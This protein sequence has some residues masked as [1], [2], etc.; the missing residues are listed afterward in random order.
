M[1]KLLFICGFPSG[2]TDLIKSI[3]NVHPDIYINGEMPLLYKIHKHGYN[4]STRFNN[5][6]EIRTFQNILSN[7]NVWD[8]IE[9]INHNFEN[10]FKSNVSLSLTQILQILFSNKDREIWGNKT[11]QNTE[12][13]NILQRIFP[14]S[15]FLIITRD[16]RDIC[17]SWKKKWGKHMLSCAHKW[18]I[19]MKTGWQY[20]KKISNNQICFVK[21]EDLLQDKFM[22][23]N[24]ICEFLEIPVSD[25]MYEHHK[26]MEN[27]IDGKINYG[28]AIKPDNMMKWEKQ[29]TPK[30]VKR[31]EEIAYNTLMIFE[32]STKYAELNKHISKFELIAGKLHDVYSL[33]FIG[34][35]AS[36]NNTISDRLRTIIQEFKKRIEY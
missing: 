17:L 24:R 26:H 27:F 10:A 36:Q 33:I 13:I 34:N 6:N 23:I 3:L 30:K 11:P 31:I 7:Y 9:N 12:N 28:K 4:A 22:S 14:E 8:N 19:R 5:I 21:Y 1:S 16:V 29:L 2:G 20:S 18:A 35:R 32:Y 25:M 15:Y